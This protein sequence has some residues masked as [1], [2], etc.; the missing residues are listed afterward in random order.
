MQCVI[1]EIIIADT[2]LAVIMAAKKY[3]YQTHHGSILDLTVDAV[4]SP[5]NSFGFMDGGVDLAY[6]RFFGKKVYE[7]LQETL[8]REKPFDELLVGQAI[9]IRTDNTQ[10]PNVV[11]APT[12][13]VPKKI[14]DPF[15][16]VL[17]TRA[18][19]VCASFNGHKTVAFPGMGT[20]VGCL[21]PETSI[22]AF[23]AGIRQVINP[24]PFPRS[25]NEAMERHMSL[26]AELEEE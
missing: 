18:A 11:C 20:G 24:M 7:T 10:I 2:N 1:P 9:N 4:V 12:M 6:T 17:A 25:I 5:A 13:R 14:S 15:D 26:R 16:I 3:G 21:N 8:M 19:Y 23:H 22:K